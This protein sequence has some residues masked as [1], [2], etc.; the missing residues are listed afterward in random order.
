MSAEETLAARSEERVVRLFPARVREHSRDG[1][2]PGQSSDAG[3]VGAEELCAR[4]DAAV[5]AKL[6]EP[7]AEIGMLSAVLKHELS[8]MPGDQAAAIADAAERADVM[9]QDLLAFVRSYVGATVRVSRRRVDLRRLCE[10]LIDAIHSKNPDRPIVFACSS[11]LE[12]QFDPD[13]VAAIVSRLVDNAIE[14]GAPRPAIR[15]EL[16]GGAAEVVFDVW[17]AGPALDPELMG[18]L[19][20]PFVCG[21]PRRPGQREGLG[22]GLY[23]ARQLVRAHGGRIDAS[24]AEHEGT[25]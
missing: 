8:D 13:V 1:V 14:H 4:L 5:E 17:N 12:G 24:S 7:I 19:F 2:A 11:Q 25:T 3:V 15:I 22:L 16:Q 23:L 6:R 20:E 21:R 10:R 9:V 18:R